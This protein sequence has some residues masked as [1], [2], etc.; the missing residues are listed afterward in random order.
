MRFSLFLPASIPLAGITFFLISFPGGLPSARADVK[1]PRLFWNHAVLQKSA[2]TPIW[3]TASEGEKITIRLGT[4]RAET[5]ADADGKWRV[6]LDLT[7]IGSGPF[8]LEIRGGNRLVFSD[9]LVGDVWLCSGQSNMFFPL[10]DSAESE[11]EIANSANPM[12][13]QFQTH[14]APSADPKQ[15]ISG[16]WVLAD[17]ATSA[18]FTAVGYYFGKTLQ[19]QLNT[20]I[21]LIHAS[22]PGS[23]IEAWIRSEALDSDQKLKAGKERAQRDWRAHQNFIEEFQAWIVG[24]QRQDKTVR[25]ADAFASTESDAITW[26]PVQMPGLFA[27]MGMPDTGAI[28]IRR[29]VKISPDDAGKNLLVSLGDL[30]GMEAIYWNGVKVRDTPLIPATT[31]SYSI[32]AKLVQDGEATLAVRIFQPIGGAGIAPGKMAFA[33]GG[34]SLSGDWEAVSEFAL[35]ALGAEALSLLPQRPLEPSMGH[36]SVAASLFN[37]YIAPLIPFG[38]RGVVWYQGESNRDRA[39]QYHTSFPL[40][41]RDWRFCWNQGDFPFYFCQI[42]NFSP[43]NAAPEESALAELREAQTRALAERATGQAILIDIGGDLHP[44]NKKDVGERLARI[45]LAQT[46]GRQ[47]ADSGP[48]FDS[49]KLEQGKIR[50]R[51]TQTDKGLV[52]GT[53][54]ETYQPD[55]RFPR[56]IPLVRNSPNSALQGFS[57]CG[58]NRQWKWADAEIQGNEVV[59]W[60]SEVPEPVAVRYAWAGNPTCNFFNTAG[61]PAA[62]FRTD[63]FPLTTQNAQY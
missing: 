26:K 53:L 6:H 27:D 32:P 54:P 40:M 43:R 15:E 17:P 49:M 12:L 25:N 9:I 7:S 13:R 51:F 37:G 19:K 50:L 1:V 42:A 63:D 44:L 47:I 8:Q 3:G 62:P 48:V 41:I 16:T 22:V 5:Q 52:A 36:S 31:H 29:K 2:K 55:I 38:I 24:Q 23:P 20:P 4:V 46:Y 10:A 18:K 33:V 60:S 45:A 39:A 35:P 58:D 14:S 56:T 57:V 34:Q 28:W 59:V 61:L 30:Q 21:G 11:M